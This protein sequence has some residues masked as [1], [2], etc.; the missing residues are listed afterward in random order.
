MLAGRH[1]G[2]TLGLAAAN[3]LYEVW[4]DDFQWV[5]FGLLIALTADA[6]VAL[7]GRPFLW[8]VQRERRAQ[9]RMS[10]VGLPV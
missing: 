8:R 9:H 6:Q 4:M 10:E 1:G 7:G 5:L 3:I 2:I